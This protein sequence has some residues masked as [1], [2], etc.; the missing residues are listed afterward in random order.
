M[1][2]SLCQ[3]SIFC[4]VTFQ[5][6]LTNYTLFIW[7][8]ILSCMA[9]YHFDFTFHLNAPGDRQPNCNRLASKGVPV[10]SQRVCF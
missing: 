4:L 5:N 7:V 3:C 6:Q 8:V 9:V 2:W 1:Y 10:F